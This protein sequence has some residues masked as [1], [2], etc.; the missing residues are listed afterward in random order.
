MKNT[1]HFI[2]H[3][4]SSFEGSNGFTTPQHPLSY[5]FRSL[6]LTTKCKISVQCKRDESFLLMLPKYWPWS[7]KPPT[8]KFSVLKSNSRSHF[9]LTYSLKT[10]IW[11]WNGKYY[12]EQ[13]HKIYYSQAMY[14]FLYELFPIRIKLAIL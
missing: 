7:V 10:K 13:Y 14:H 9:N 8:K 2:V 1:C 12:T 5:I 11:K 3:C 6:S 4:I